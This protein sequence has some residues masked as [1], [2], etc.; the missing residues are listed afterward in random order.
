MRARARYD[1]T[2]EAAAAGNTDQATPEAH[3][4]IASPPSMPTRRPRSIRPTRPAEYI[5]AFSTMFGTSIRKPATLD[6][7][8]LRFLA[9]AALEQ[10]A[11]KPG[12]VL[13]AGSHRSDPVT[14]IA[15][16]ESNLPDGPLGAFTS[17]AASKP[18]PNR[19]PS[20]LIDNPP[21]SPTTV[22][23]TGTRAVLPASGA[24]WFQQTEGVYVS[25]RPK[26]K[27]M[28][29]WKAEHGIP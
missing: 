15:S 4:S 16:I 11:K 25:Q 1:S 14:S 28:G 7:S 10:R 21:F 18:R 22:D 19:L 24:G 3:K 9:D 12:R 29:Q 26:S 8:P 27:W 23:P 17:N 6:T 13:Q 2:K 20:Q 5:Q